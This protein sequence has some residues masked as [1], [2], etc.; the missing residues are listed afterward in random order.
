MMGRTKCCARDLLTDV[1]VALQYSQASSRASEEQINSRGVDSQNPDSNKPL[2]YIR[3]KQTKGGG[4]VVTQK[5]KKKRSM[6]VTPSNVRTPQPRV[7]NKNLGVRKRGTTTSGT[8]DRETEIQPEGE[9]QGSRANKENTTAT[10]E[11]ISRGGL[12]GNTKRDEDED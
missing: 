9:V 8:E 12:Q 2:M 7:G 6:E 5:D 10:K 1:H 4:R 3:R 11:T